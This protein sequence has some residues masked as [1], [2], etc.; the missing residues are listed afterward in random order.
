MT[1]KHKYFLFLVPFLL[2]MLAGMGPTQLVR[3][4]VYDNPPLSFVDEEGIA[5]GFVVDLLREI[6]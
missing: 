3:V 4:G 1:I 5:Q 6:A 2:F